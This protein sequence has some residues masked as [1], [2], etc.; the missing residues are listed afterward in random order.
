[1]PKQLIKKFEEIIERP[2]EYSEQGNG[3]IFE[4][5]HVRFFEHEEPIFLFKNNNG[6][7]F[8]M[9]YS[10]YEVKTDDG[11]AYLFHDLEENEFHMY[12]DYTY[13]FSFVFEDG[14]V[15]KYYDNN[16]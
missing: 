7:Y 8:K 13:Q 14:S 4:G 6:Y 10:K 12:E 15:I 16:Q 9:K 2:T 1:M 11:Y 3:R 5:K